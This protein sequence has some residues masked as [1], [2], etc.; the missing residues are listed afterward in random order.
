MKRRSVPSISL[1]LAAVLL[2]SGCGGT[3]DATEGKTP[4]EV[5]TAAKEHFDTARS[6]HMT[7]STDATPSRGDAVLGAEGTLTQQPA[8]E[9]E[10]TVVLGGFNADVPVISV[11][12]TVYAK[13][14]LTPRYTAIDPAEYGAPD[15]AAFADPERGIS[16][17][18]LEL[19]EPERSGRKRDGD[20]VLTTFKGTLSGDLVA[21]I[22]P[23]ADEDG[24]YE[25][26]VGIDDK[27]RIVSLRVT[28]DFFEHDGAVTYDLTLDDYGRSVTVDVP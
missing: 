3:S 19:D 20:Q 24:T 15:P 17:L 18:L 5:L 12:G 22:I 8:F 9:G 1:V 4:L 14:P 26:T 2:A 28:G 13:L 7:L 16:S 21:P 10:V 27:G 11:N 23:S 25:T 6:V